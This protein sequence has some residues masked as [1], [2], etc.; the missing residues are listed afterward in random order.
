MERSGAGQLMEIRETEMAMQKL[1]EKLGHWPSH[2][3][4]NEAYQEVIKAMLPEPQ[5]LQEYPG[6]VLKPPEWW[7]K[8]HTNCH[9][10][11]P[12]GD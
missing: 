11:P 3:E 6:V 9:C 2:D 7:Q 1:A 5:F 12:E 10:T 8:L 4:I